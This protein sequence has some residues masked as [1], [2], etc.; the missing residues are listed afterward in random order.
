VEAR[1]ASVPRITLHNGNLVVF[2]GTHVQC[3]AFGPL[4]LPTG[5]GKTRGILC[6]VGP[7]KTYY[8]GT[9]YMEV[10]TSGY[11]YF[12]RI[13]MCAN[14][15]DAATGAPAPGTGGVAL[16]DRMLV[17]ISYDSNRKLHVE[18]RLRHP[19]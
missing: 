7:P 12:K 15:V 17:R 2:K 19:G 1:I 11:R 13:V 5:I 10:T 16:S 8:R 18:S 3:L 4:E 9:Y 14:K 6:F